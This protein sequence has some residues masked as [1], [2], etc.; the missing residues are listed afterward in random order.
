MLAMSFVLEYGE[1]TLTGIS[2]TKPD[3]DEPWSICGHLYTP[4]SG[5]IDRRLHLRAFGIPHW[6]LDLESRSHGLAVPILREIMP[7]TEDTNRGMTSSFSRC[8]L[9]ALGGMDI[10]QLLFHR[11][12]AM[13]DRW[14]S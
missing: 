8:A 9:P 5:E 3:G 11:V 7:N 6:Y 2:R 10:E 12:H 4:I 13:K 14:I 1:T